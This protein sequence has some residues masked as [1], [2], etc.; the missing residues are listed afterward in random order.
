MTVQEPDLLLRVGLVDPCVPVRRA[1]AIAPGHRGDAA[2]REALIAELALDPSR[3]VIE[4]LAAI[5]DDGAI[6]HLDRC[7][8]RHPALAGA[9]VDALRDMESA[10]AE[11]LAGRLE[12]RGRRPD[13]DGG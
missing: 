6:V 9:V 12:A 5:G 4:A 1:A 3:E 2:A 10:R 11:R 8:E 7:A 13:A